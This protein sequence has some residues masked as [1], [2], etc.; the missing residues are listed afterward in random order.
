LNGSSK[1]PKHT[2]TDRSAHS[3]RKFQY[4]YIEEERLEREW[5]RDEVQYKINAEEGS[6]TKR[7]KMNL[8]QMANDENVKNGSL[9][10]RKQ[11]HSYWNGEEKVIGSP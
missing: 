8:S 5:G 9:N 2:T 6:M 10:N 4:A 1:R 7:N 11:L 3:T